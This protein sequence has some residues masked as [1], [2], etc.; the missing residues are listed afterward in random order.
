M[1]NAKIISLSDLKWHIIVRDLNSSPMIGQFIW[2]RGSLDKSIKYDL[3]VCMVEV[4]SRRL[5]V[6]PCESS[7]KAGNDTM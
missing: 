2:G 4:P 5:G 1:D 7:F 3:T 6:T